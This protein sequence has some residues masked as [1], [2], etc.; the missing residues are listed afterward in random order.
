[1]RL[2]GLQL[3]TALPGLDARVLGSGSRRDKI[4]LGLGHDCVDLIRLLRNYDA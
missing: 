1:M 2:R 3:C 4:E